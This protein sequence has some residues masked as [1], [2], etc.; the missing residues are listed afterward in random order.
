[1]ELLAAVVLFVYLV[2]TVARHRRRL[3]TE[4]VHLLGTQALVVAAV[5]SVMIRSHNGEHPSDWGPDSDILVSVLAVPALIGPALTRGRLF[6]SM[7]CVVAALAW[8]GFL[9]G[10]DMTCT[11]CGFAMGIPIALALPQLGLVVVSVVSGAI[12]RRIPGPVLRGD[13]Q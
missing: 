12:A 7:A 6:R 10:G 1:M 13:G 9:F 3:W 2:A 5:V 11:D 8:V 4:K